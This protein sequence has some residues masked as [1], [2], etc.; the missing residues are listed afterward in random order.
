MQYI[1]A[2]D[3]MWVVFV[4]LANQSS[5]FFNDPNQTFSVLNLLFAQRVKER[6]KELDRRDGHIE[7]KV[8]PSLFVLLPAETQMRAT[9]F[10][11]NKIF[12]L[13]F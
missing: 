1:P 6:W 4:I 9:N 8:V 11:L 10:W 12:K 2:R 7:M 5:V 3:V 13:K